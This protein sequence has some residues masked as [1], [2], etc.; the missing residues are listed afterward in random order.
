MNTYDFVHLALYA[1]DEKIKGKT[2]FQKTIYF[3]GKL[4]GH[5]DELGYHAHYYGPYS[6]QVA[7]AADR[8]RSLDFLEQ[9]IACGGVVDSFGFE[10]ARYDFELNKEGKEVACSKTK[11]YPKFWEKLS[12]AVSVFKKAGDLDYHAL[13]IAAKTYF[14]LGRERGRVGVSQIQKT[15]EKFGWSVGAHEIEKAC[16]FLK[17]LGLVKLVGK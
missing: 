12:E 7:E 8:L 3:L 17:K 5:L 16:V 4:T 2:K 1:I 13:S 15:A 14:L 10:V 9:T 11:D 6:S